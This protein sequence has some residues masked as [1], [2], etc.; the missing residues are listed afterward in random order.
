MSLQKA[1]WQAALQ[2]PKG[3]SKKTYQNN[4]QNNKVVPMEVNYASTQ[5][6]TSYLKC[7]TPDERKKLMDE[8]RCFK[9]HLKGHQARQCP[10]KG[11]GQGSNLSTARNTETPQNKVKTLKKDPPLAYNENQITGLIRAMS[12][13]QRETLLSKVASSNKGKECKV[14]DDRD[15]SFQS[16]NEEYF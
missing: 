8:G 16:D 12:T 5:K 1:K 10:T 3:G 2:I 14:M 4:Q 9:C 13:Q 11:Q 6:Q 7:L 15:P